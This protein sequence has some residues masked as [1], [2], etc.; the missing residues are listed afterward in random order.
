VRAGTTS[1]AELLR[2]LD[3]PGAGECEPAVAGGPVVASGGNAP[4]PVAEPI[5]ACA[6]PTGIAAVAPL[7]GR[8]DPPP[9]RIGS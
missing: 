7:A 2:V 1:V 3:A 5:G 6:P 8:P 4:P 9:S